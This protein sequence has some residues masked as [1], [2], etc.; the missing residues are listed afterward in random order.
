MKNYCDTEWK[1][2]P[3]A[4]A[5]NQAYEE[6][7]ISVENEKINALEQEL[8]SMSKK[9][10]REKKKTERQ[11]KKIDELMAVNQ[12]FT[13]VNNKL[14]A[15]RKNLY[16]ELRKTKE[17]LE[18]VN[19]TIYAQMMQLTEIYEVRMAYLIEK[20]GGILIEDDVKEWAAGYEIAIQRDD[21]EQFTRSWKVIKREVEKDEES[22]GLD[23][24]TETE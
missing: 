11:Q 15:Q 16:K 23:K 20:T 22:D 8:R 18:T 1:E 3:Y 5:L 14:E 17:E 6:G 9:L 7:E 19:K 10:G 13:S 21:D 12:S 4:C 2:C 24:K